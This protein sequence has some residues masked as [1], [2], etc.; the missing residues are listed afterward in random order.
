MFGAGDAESIARGANS[1]SGWVGMSAS[2]ARVGMSA[3]RRRAR[4]GNEDTRLHRHPPGASPSPAGARRGRGCR[5]AWGG[6]A[7]PPPGSSCGTRAVPARG[8]EGKGKRPR[9]RGD[10]QPQSAAAPAG[11]APHTPP[12]HHPAG[13]GAPGFASALCILMVL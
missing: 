12:E 5:H 8:G 10:W 6:D 4:Q 3:R 9:P 13:E 11:S 2:T 7:L 1:Q